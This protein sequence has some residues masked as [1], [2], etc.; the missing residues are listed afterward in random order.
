MM[1][2]PSNSVWRASTNH[3]IFFR[4]G[5]IVCY[6]VRSLSDEM[7][8]ATFLRTGFEL[9]PRSISRTAMRISAALNSILELNSS[10]PKVQPSSTAINGFT[11]PVVDTFEGVLTRSNQ[12]YAVN[13]ANDP[14]NVR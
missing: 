1:G 10:L 13:A 8:E 7:T 14:N 2:K 11:N 9:A 5:D 3:R 6:A 12:T 4:R